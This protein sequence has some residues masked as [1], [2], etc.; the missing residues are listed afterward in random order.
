MA[1]EL[2]SAEDRVLALKF[3]AE[4]D[5]EADALERTAV[6]PSQVTQ[7]QMQVQQGPAL[8]ENKDEEKKP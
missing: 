4:L 5:A 8:Q 2:H 7:V 3:A 1:R 6:P